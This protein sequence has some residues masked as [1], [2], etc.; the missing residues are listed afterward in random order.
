MLNAL[1]HP[2]YVQHAHSAC[3]PMIP[4]E[5]LDVY[6]IFMTSDLCLRCGLCARWVQDF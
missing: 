1:P 3:V 4:E 2:C 6:V 5:T